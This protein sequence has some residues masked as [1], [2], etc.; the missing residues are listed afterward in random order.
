MGTRSHIG[1]ENQDGTVRYIYCN[2]D[3]YPDHNGKI[4]IEN[5]FLADKINELL[6]LGDISSLAPEIGEKHD[7][8]N[9]PKNQCNVY[10]RD[11]G[12]NN[13]KS[14]TV[15][16]IDQFLKLADEDYT[17]LFRN[18]KWFFRNWKKPLEELTPAAYTELEEEE[19]V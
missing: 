12:E 15:G 5:Y 3:G 9:P 10:G 4:L 19:I 2:W 8:D 1:I 11:R 13:T 17:Y 7:F 14:R 16:D 6:D 18:G